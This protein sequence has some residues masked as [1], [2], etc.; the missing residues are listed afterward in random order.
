VLAGVAAVT[1]LICT[2]A[3]AA[4]GAIVEHGLGHPAAATPIKP[5]LPTSAEPSTNTT[6]V[7][8]S[9]GTALYA[10]VMKPP[11]G[12]RVFTVVNSSDG[13]LDVDQY[14]R[15]YFANDPTMPGVLR[16]EGFV[17]AAGRDFRRPDG[18]EVVVHLTRFRS[19][20]GA[21]AAMDFVLGTWRGD[22]SV[23]G[24]FTAP[25]NGHGLEMSTPNSRGNRRTLMLATVGDILVTVDVYT[26]GKIDK[27]VDLARLDEQLN[28][29]T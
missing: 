3:G 21:F 11:P 19:S 13:V 7:P 16:Q 15:Q 12:S 25:H 2:I 27:A 23:T 26:P 14:G 1:A 22:D 9:V 18:D 6:V 24:R 29:L 8:L 17:I 10:Q 28:L 20:G 5:L 4:G